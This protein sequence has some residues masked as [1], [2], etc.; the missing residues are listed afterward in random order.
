MKLRAVALALLVALA[1]ARPA[2]ADSAVEALG[3]AERALD[4]GRYRDALDVLDSSALPAETGDLV[5]LRRAE[6]AASLGDAERALRELARP[7]LANTPNRV[8]MTR[9]A[10]VAERVGSYG[11][12]G[13]LWTRASRQ[14]SWSAEKANAM[15]NAALDFT[16]A[17]L[18]ERAADL[19]AALVDANLTSPKLA[20]AL[21]PAAD[22]GAHHSAL[23]A[24][25]R[26][27]AAS[28]A[29]WL[30]GYLKARPNGDYAAAA[31]RRLAALARVTV[32]DGWSATRDQDTAAG[33]AAWVAAHPESPRVPEA[34]FFQ[35]LALYRGGDFSGAVDV[36]SA[37]TG[38]DSAT[39]V[40][41][42]ALYWMAKADE[43]LDRTEAARLRLST[44]AALKPTSYY[45]ARAADR[46]KGAVAWPDGGVALPPAATPAEELEVERWIASWA[47]WA[48]APVPG[49]A[50]ALTRADLFSS[51]G[52]EQTATA[53]LNR[54][55]QT[56]EDPRVVY[57]AGKL[58]YAR[59]LWTSATRAG[60]RLG[61]M[62]PATVSVDAPVGVRRLSYPP[63]YGAQVAYE[64]G[65]NNVGP[66]LLLSLMRQ[67]SFFDRF[68][69][70]VAE[71]RGLTQVIPPT[72][73]HLAKSLGRATFRPD[74]LYDPDLAIAFGA[75]YL[76]DQLTYFD[77]DVFRAVAA[78]NA[79]GGA[80]ARWARGTAD[81]DL[82]V[83]SIGYAETREY[84]KSIYQYH[85]AYRALVG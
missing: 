83:E 4:A 41:A 59:R 84:V 81:P 76:R 11:L 82:F 43:Q 27:D 28:A 73:A 60:A 33:Y 67:E 77:G 25:I 23:V 63:A 51:V 85:A 7:E 64:S 32:S 21:A 55:I 74:D 18:Q 80:A 70:S 16:R 65:Q 44:A 2:L 20:D 66:L 8:L 68:A 36:W 75:R 1:S 40:R 6:A 35:G 14:P 10:V 58:A 31:Q 30:R 22:L 24:L 49:D 9:A 62:S 50:T 39:D 56:T 5:A 69:L 61:A 37:W 47:G 13:E 48:R 78:Y 52:L 71:A 15:R 42:R 12:A 19:L 54:L 46:L 26:G 72:G 79:G 3:R 29:E 17:G 53:E 57:Q 45:S 38:P 34:R